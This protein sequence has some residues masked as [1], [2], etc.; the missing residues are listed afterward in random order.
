MK[1]FTVILRYAANQD[2]ID[3]AMH[4]HLDFVHDCYDKEIFL[5]SGPTTPRQ[6]AVIL[7]QATDRQRLLDILHT[8]PFFEKGLCE[9]AVHEFLP[10][11][12]HS[13]LVFFNRYL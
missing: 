4:E 3:N 11:R 5:L 13:E 2:A 10:S 9:F 6:G 1:L 12:H 8:D 7:A